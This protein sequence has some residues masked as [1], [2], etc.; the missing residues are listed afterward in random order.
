[1]QCLYD[2]KL[3]FVIKTVLLAVI[4]ENLLKNILTVKLILNSMEGTNNY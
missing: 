1:M 2:K 4:N 3:E